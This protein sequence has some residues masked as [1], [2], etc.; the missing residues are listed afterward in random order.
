MSKLLERLKFIFGGLI[1]PNM[2]MLLFLLASFRWYNYTATEYSI[3]SN[4]MKGTPGAVD[5]TLLEIWIENY[6]FS[7]C[8]LFVCCVVFVLYNIIAMI[9]C[10]CL[11][12]PR[13]CPD[14]L[15][16][17][18]CESEEKLSDEAGVPAK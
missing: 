2:V 13:D 10:V 6:I 12:C 1:L 9:S 14:S 5:V 16:E 11:S 15:S 18:G 8:T 7:S 3:L 4:R 17:A